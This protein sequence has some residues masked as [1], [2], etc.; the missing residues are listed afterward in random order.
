MLV[1]LLATA[2]VCL[3]VSSAFTHQHA[4]SAA[5]HSWGATLRALVSGR[6]AT[7]TGPAIAFAAVGD[8]GKAGD[9]AKLAAAVVCS[10]V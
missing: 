5:G 2:V 6:S 8:F 10:W 4:G 9:E 3:M 7:A 1:S